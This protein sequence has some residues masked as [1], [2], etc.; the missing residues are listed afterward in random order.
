MEE[1]RRKMKKL[2][3]EVDVEMIAENQHRLLI[4]PKETKT[5]TT[6]KRNEMKMK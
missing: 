5:K 2:R 3:A 1:I 4:Y 6:L